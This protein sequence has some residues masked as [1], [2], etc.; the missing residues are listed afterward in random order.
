VILPFP[1]KLIEPLE[2]SN[3][4][5]E[6]MKYMRKSYYNEYA[7]MYHPLSNQH[8]LLEN[9]YDEN[10]N[11]FR[12]EINS[13]NESNRNGK[14]RLE[15][16][17]FEIFSLEYGE[18]YFSLKFPIF[19]SDISAY[20]T[21]ASFNNQFYNCKLHSI[22]YSDFENVKEGEV[23]L[24]LEDFFNAHY[25]VNSQRKSAFFELNSD[26][27]CFNDLRKKIF[28]K[29]VYYT[30][31]NKKRKKITNN[32]SQK[33]NRH[34]LSFIQRKKASIN[35]YFRDKFYLNSSF[36]EGLRDYE[37]T[38]E[39][40]IRASISVSV[41]LD[42]KNNEQEILLKETYLQ[43][44]NVKEEFKDKFIFIDDNIKPYLLKDK[45]FISLELMSNDFYSRLV[46][47]VST[48]KQRDA[49]L[50]MFSFFQGFNSDDKERTTKQIYSFLRTVF[51]HTKNGRINSEQFPNEDK[52][53]II[54]KEFEFDSDVSLNLI[55]EPEDAWLYQSGNGIVEY[56][57]GTYLP[58]KGYRDVEW[59]FNPS[60][61]DFDI[62]LVINSSTNIEYEANITEID[63]EE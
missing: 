10:L 62:N 9:F 11:N 53:N 50:K 12:D 33:F 41:N 13:L 15:F 14:P 29:L 28:Q 18:K 7:Y 22:I 5:I 38:V 34:I 23:Q 61:E 43:L 37:Y 48:L 1:D 21:W 26:L 32:I 47:I 45:S 4:Y 20:V 2:Q 60:K 36:L 49:N 3:G 63:E 57:G 39:D 16:P 40:Y 42:N 17:P 56:E 55:Y 58:Y 19:G 54:I 44:Y 51:F 46:N 27:F 6:Y 25:E 24:W 30:D 59:G 52:A 35:W 8:E 31:A